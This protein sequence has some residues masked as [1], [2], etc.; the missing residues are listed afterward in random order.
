MAQ[1]ESIPDFF[2]KSGPLPPSFDDVRRYPRF[3]FRTVAEATIY[4]IGKAQQPSDCFLLT[5]D[6]SRSGMSLLH[7]A[8]LFPGQRMEV[9]LNGEPPRHVVVVWCKRQSPGNYLIGCKFTAAAE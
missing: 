9:I 5:R 3:Y 6:L 7:N 1:P 4:P 8:Q 2:S